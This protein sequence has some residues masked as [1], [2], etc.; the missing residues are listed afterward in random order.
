MSF[1]RKENDEVPA[2]V[3]CC[4][5]SGCALWPHILTPKSIAKVCN[6]G[7]GALLPAVPWPPVLETTAGV[8]PELSEGPNLALKR[9]AK[10][11]FFQIPY[12]FPMDF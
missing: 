9:S 3:F 2:A 11:L 4:C 1:K 8:M 12:I 5:N 7:F 10:S 6:P